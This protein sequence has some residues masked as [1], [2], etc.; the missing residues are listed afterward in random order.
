MSEN[1]TS[2]ARVGIGTDVHRLV[3]G[4]PLHLAGLAWPDAPAGLEGHSDGDCAAHA[5]V[6][7]LLAAA[8]LG[9]I[10]SHFGTSDPRW[11]RAS[12]VAFLVETARVLREAG[13]AVVNASV[14]V[15]GTEPKVGPRRAEAEAALSGAIGAPV[16]VS[17]TTTDG[18]GLTG[19]GEGIAAIAVAMVAPV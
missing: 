2:A 6:D 8:G 9:D 13:Y 5:L 10:G 18:L 16:S 15:I 1:G 7:A 11:D 12:G 17:G 3:P 19:R 14:Q 4:R